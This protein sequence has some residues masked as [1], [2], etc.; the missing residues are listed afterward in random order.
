M[1][2]TDHLLLTE[3]ARIEESFRQLEYQIKQIQLNNLNLEGHKLSLEQNNPLVILG[4]VLNLTGLTFVDINNLLLG[5][6]FPKNTPQKIRTFIM[7]GA[8][9]NETFLKKAFDFEINL[10]FIVAKYNE[11]YASHDTVEN[12]RVNIHNFNYCINY[13]NFSL[14]VNYNFRDY[15]INEII[16][17]GYKLNKNQLSKLF[18]IA[19]TTVANILKKNKI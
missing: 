5:V 16:V 14:K 17:A 18:S 13:I 15:L 8:N 3:E 10:E 11:F 4:A 6:W 12:F 9:V 2:K 19:P 1:T 7:E